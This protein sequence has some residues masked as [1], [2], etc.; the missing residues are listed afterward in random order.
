V[1]QEVFGQAIAT[2]LSE[3]GY[4]VSPGTL[5]PTLHYLERKNFLSGRWVTVEGK[6]RR[7]Y[8]VTPKGM[9][10][11]SHMK[12]FLSELTQVILRTKLSD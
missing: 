12:P 2:R 11:L 4:A 1:D 9:A 5:Y 6:R 8:R 3:Y 7:Y 10:F